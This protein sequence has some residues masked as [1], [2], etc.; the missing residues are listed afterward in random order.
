MSFDSVGNSKHNDLQLR[1]G[2][3]TRYRSGKPLDQNTRVRTTTIHTSMCIRFPKFDGFSRE[4]ITK[5]RLT[6]FQN[7]IIHRVLLEI[8]NAQ[9]PRCSAKYTDERFS[10]AFRFVF[11][12]TIS[13]CIVFTKLD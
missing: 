10:I 7:A 11:P 12:E 2:Q 9:T 4:N 8:I 1:S 13:N 3:Q 5:R 6:T